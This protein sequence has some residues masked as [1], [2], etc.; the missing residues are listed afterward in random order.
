MEEGTTIREDICSESAIAGRYAKAAEQYG[1]KAGRR[2]A[3]H[4][5]PKFLGGPADGPTSGI[6]AAYHQQITN[7]F[8]EAATSRGIGYGGRVLDPLNSASDMLDL[9]A[10]L[11]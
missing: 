7:A 10:I 5:V 8:R 1:A 3:H 11:Q 6:D 2:E 4:I 9:I